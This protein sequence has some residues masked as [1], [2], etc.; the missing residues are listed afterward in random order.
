MA[1][2][3]NATPT[4]QLV[5]VI[6]MFRGSDAEIFV[7]VVYGELTDDQKDEWRKAHSCDDYYK[8]EDPEDWDDVRNMFFR[9]LE[10]RENDYNYELLNAG[11]LWSIRPRGFGKS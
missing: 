5:T 6:T 8:P 7:Q 11:E 10:I 4:K 2:S 1:N 9:V 3:P